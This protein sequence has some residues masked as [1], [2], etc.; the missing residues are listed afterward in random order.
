M[1]VWTMFIL[2][3]SLGLQVSLS[4]ASDLGHRLEPRKLVKREARKDLPPDF[5]RRRARLGGLA[6]ARLANLSDINRR[7]N[8]T[9]WRR[10][11]EA[12]AAG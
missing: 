10:Q 8:L 4:I 6:R 9:R 12:Q 5:L 7:A 2:F 1:S 11:R 3:E